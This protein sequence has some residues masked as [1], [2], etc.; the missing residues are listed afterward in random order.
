MIKY[1][2]YFAKYTDYFI[3]GDENTMKWYEKGWVIFLLLL[4]VFPIGVFLLWK[5][6]H[7][8]KPA[9]I[10]A[11]VIF[12][13][14]FIMAIIP[15]PKEANFDISAEANKPAEDNNEAQTN[16][17]QTNEP[18]N[19]PETVESKPEF[20][21]YETDLSSGNYTAG[22]DFPAG[23]YDIEAI[24]GLGN[25]S[26]SNMFSGGINDMMGIDDG[27]GLYQKKY[28]NIKLTKGVVLNVSGGVVIHI[29]SDAASSDALTPRNQDITETQTLGNGNWVSGTDFPAGIYD[30]EAISGSG[31]VSSDNMFNGGINAVMG[32]E[33]DI[34]DMS[35]KSY[36]N[37]EFP[38]GTT[39]SISGCE[40]TLTPS[41]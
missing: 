8:R 9:K 18:I 20:I 24:S 17:A 34:W 4:F 39:L 14:I 41:K 21:S 37:I 15:T 10:I 11:T 16:E 38:E 33:N 23:I 36:K 2:I 35:E 29:N 19:E 12:G 27:S 6:G 28:S 22:I 5:Y 31:N 25:V 1:F 26:S 13:F 7:W 40:I 32:T 30:I 3:K